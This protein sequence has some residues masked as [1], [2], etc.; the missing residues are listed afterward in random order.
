MDTDSIAVAVAAAVA[1]SPQVRA[2]S[3][4]AVVLGALVTYAAV[5]TVLRVVAHTIKQR[6]NVARLSKIPGPPSEG[7]F[8]AML[9][10]ARRSRDR[11]DWAGEQYEAL[12]P[13]GTPQTFK[14]QGS[15]HFPAGG[16]LAND[17]RTCEP[18]NVQHI[19]KDNFDNYVKSAP[20]GRANPLFNEWLGTGIFTIDHGENARVPLD[21]GSLWYAQHNTAARIFTTANFR[22]FY[23]DT[24]IANGHTLMKYFESV[25]D[26]QAVDVQRGMFAYTM[27]SFGKIAFGVDMGNLSGADSAFGEAFDGAHSSIFSF[28]FTNTKKLLMREVFPEP[29]G[30]VW[31]KAF[32]QLPSQHY[33]EF[34]QHN[35]T[36]NKY[37][38]RVIKQRRSDPDCGKA[39]DLLGLFMG[40]SDEV[41][42]R[43]YTDEELRDVIM[44]FIIAGRDTTACTLS[45]MWYELGQPA[46]AAV[47]Q[48]LI[49][50]VDTVL[51]GEEPTFAVLDRDM[52]YLRGVVYEVLRLH[53]IVPHTALVAV[54][55]DTLP[56]GTPVPAGTRVFYDTY[57]MCRSEK[58][59]GEDALQLKPERWIPFKRP[60]QYEFPVFKGGPRL[61]LGMNMAIFE[62][63]LLAAMT[64]QKF[65]FELEP[66]HDYGYSRQATISVYDKKADRAQLLVNVKKRAQ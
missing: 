53:P 41:S 21:R 65:T 62:A 31:E 39:S 51:Q 12:C 9:H 16:G 45:W 54:N 66:G 44:N 27:D 25:A 35:A 64:L 47:L 2:V 60:S 17:I 36:L 1:L 50:E 22:T 10:M 43:R 14:V 4:L 40:A 46:N 34:K 56:D 48:R 33:W 49:E 61:C 18:R 6:K 15:P 7:L 55:D 13:E 37:V 3:P 42:G 28:M 26:G 30:R 20:A 63:S 8:G 58:T 57:V 59:W 19:L 32:C 5:G 52:P 11:F 29:F 23:Q 38:Y 24:F